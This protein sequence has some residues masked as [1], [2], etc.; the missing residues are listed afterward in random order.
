MFRNFRLSIIV[1]FLGCVFS[2]GAQSG[3]PL[4]I[5]S[6]SSN[7]ELSEKV[8]SYLGISLSK[9]R[10]GRFNDGEIQIQLEDSVRNQDV[11]VIQS[12]CNSK[13]ASINDNIMELFLLIR[14]LK[15]SSS[16][17][18]T[19]VMPY[20][21]YARQDRKQKPRV[22]ISASD[23][24]MLIESAGASRVV[25]VDLHCGQ[26]QGFFQ[27]TPVDNLF[28]IS[29]MVSYM[30]SVPL[31]NPVVVSPDAGGVARAKK[32]REA[33]GDQGI[34]AGL[35]IFVKQRGEAG[36][37]D[38]VDLVGEVEGRDVIIVDDMCDTGGTLVSV[39]NELKKFGAKKVYVCV[40]HPVFSKNAIKLI[41][42]SD[43]TEMIT[44]DTIPIKG[45]LPSNIKQISIAPLL[46]KAMNLIHN[47]QPI[48]TLFGY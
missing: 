48:T 13:D 28:S 32:F 37:I 40:T 26:I 42:D 6:G 20:Y 31:E 36:V 1:L 14:T 12:T 47:N 7:T 16:G 15:R 46:A 23:I 11:F 27:Q 30:K 2:V 24:A 38:A 44:T 10:L 8:A 34:S 39:V 18:I 3:K 45:E 4:M 29:S 19:V 43:I 25:A 17:Q 35:A 41:G 22:P 9:T 5:F 21:G 33:L